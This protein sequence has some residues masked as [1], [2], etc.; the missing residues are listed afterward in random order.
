M[1]NLRKSFAVATALVVG[2]VLFGAATSSQAQE[3][4]VTL[5]G[6]F[7]FTGPYADTGPLMD[8]ATKIALEEVNY[9]VAGYKIKYVTRDSETKAGAATRRVEEAI[10]SEGVDFVIGRG[11]GVS[12]W[13]SR[14]SPRTA[15]FCTITA[16][17]TT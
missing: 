10:A 6:L 2:G 13:R 9:Q 3:K 1:N 11:R 12:A 16:A 17:V 8:A 4:E 7:P 15:S 5:L 14:K